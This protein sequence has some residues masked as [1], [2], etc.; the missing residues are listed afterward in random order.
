MATNDFIQDLVEKMSDDSVEYIVIALQKGKNDIEGPKSH[1][2]YNIST[3]I[4]AEMIVQT[5]SE[6]F[7]QDDVKILLDDDDFKEGAD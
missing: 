1:A 4:G 7:Q 5:M 6:V 3:P 2:F